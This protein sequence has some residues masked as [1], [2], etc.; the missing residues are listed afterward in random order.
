MVRQLN[1]QS[2]ERESQETSTIR[3][4]YF[5]P[6]PFHATPHQTITRPFT[7][8]EESNG[9][10]VSQASAHRPITSD[11]CSETGLQ[12]PTHSTH[13]HSAT[14]P[15][16]LI[17]PTHHHPSRSHPPQIFHNDS[18]P[19]P[20][21][22]PPH[23]AQHGRHLDSCI[24]L[25]CHTYFQQIQGAGIGSQ[26]SPA[27]CN[28]AITLI[29][30]AWQDTYHTFLQQPNLHLFNTRCVDNRYILLNDNFLHSLPITTLAHPDLY[31]HPVEIETVEDDHLLGFLI[32]PQART[33]TFQLPSH[34]SQIRDTQSAGSY[35]LRLFGLQ[36]RHHTLQQSTFPSELAFTSAQALAHQY[37]VLQRCSPVVSEKRHASRSSLTFNLCLLPLVLVAPISAFCVCVCV[38]PWTKGFPPPLL[39]QFFHHL[40]HAGGMAAVSLAMPTK[41]WDS[42]G[43]ECGRTFL[44]QRRNC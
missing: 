10:P 34:P 2:L 11:T 17:A 41:L 7:H 28:V 1:A 5:L 6:A 43:R 16:P 31:G 21:N 44:Y 42:A 8:N 36:S 40:S 3:R 15:L 27:L 33:I 39:S 9:A 18:P 32:N 26:L 37:I 13:P 24:F 19:P 14:P 4:S 25:S 35:R 23:T 38:H 22:H 29:E 30:H 12:P 20:P